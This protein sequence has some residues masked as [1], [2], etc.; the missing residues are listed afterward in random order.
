[1]DFNE[2]AMFVKVVQ[3]GSFSAAGRQLGLPTSTIS[4]RVARLEQRLGVTL[5]QRTTRRLHL[6]EAGVLFF[7][8]ASTG[9]GYLLE[10]EAA[11][12]AVRQQPRGLLRVTAPADLGDVILGQLVQRTQSQYAQLSFE[13]M[14]TERY[15]DLVAEGVDMAIRTGELKDSS[16]I[17]KSLGRIQWALFASPHYLQDSAPLNT[18]SD[19]TQHACVQFTSLGRQHWDLHRGSTSLRVPVPGSTLANSIGVVRAMAENGLGIA[20]LPAFICQPAVQAG[21]LQ[22]VLPDWL[23][24]ADAVHLVYPQQRFMPPKLRACIEVAMTTLTPLFVAG[25]GL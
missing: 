17:A 11:L 9:L 1:M 25:A 21:A 18:P 2:A 14:L 7:E 23:G 22:R 4:T 3:T 5:L 16:L 24:P 13:L 12:D 10:A 20:L 15:V 19:L 6:T 8:H